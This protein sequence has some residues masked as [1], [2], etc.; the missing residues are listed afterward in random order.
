MKKIL[1][2]SVAAILCIAIV[3]IAGDDKKMGGK[4]NEGTIAKLDMAGKMMVVKDSAGK[5]TTWP[6]DPDLRIPENRLKALIQNFDRWD[7]A[8]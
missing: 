1:G 8:E 6:E 4:A 2:L 5:E 3:A 7:T